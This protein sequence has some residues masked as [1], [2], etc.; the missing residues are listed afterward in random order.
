[1]PASLSYYFPLLAL[2]AGPLGPETALAGSLALTYS[3]GLFVVGA[4]GVG[5][6]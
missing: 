4:R 3:L 6:P 5:G 1:M 2:R